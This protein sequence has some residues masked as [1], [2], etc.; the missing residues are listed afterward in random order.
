MTRVLYS[1]RHEESPPVRLQS[2]Q[3][4]GAAG[5]HCTVAEG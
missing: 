5:L 4:L 1:D 2:K 3:Q